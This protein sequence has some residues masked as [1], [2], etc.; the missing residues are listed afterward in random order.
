MVSIPTM[1][2]YLM[3]SIMAKPIVQTLEAKQLSNDI[4]AT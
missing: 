4:A 1:G 2:V 3:V